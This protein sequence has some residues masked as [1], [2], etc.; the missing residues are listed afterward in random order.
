M[1]SLV[2]IESDATLR[3][4]L[5]CLLECTDQPVI[6][7]TSAPDA[8]PFLQMS[9]GVVTVIVTDA[10]PELLRL[11]GQTSSPYAHR[12]VLLPPTFITQLIHVQRRLDRLLGSAERHIPMLMLPHADVTLAQWA[13]IV[14][15]LPPPSATGRPTA[16]L[17]QTLNG[18]VYIMRTGTPWHTMPKRYGSSVTCWRYWRQWQRDGTW[19]RIQAVLTG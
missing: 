7:F 4:L 11:L 15:I 17:Q 6:D 14:A 8:F 9:S 12:L 13:L 3:P 10:G 5:H 2:L 18:I 1:M 16:N 19:Q